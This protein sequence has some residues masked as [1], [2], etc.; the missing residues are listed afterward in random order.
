MA[1]MF[2]T[3]AIRFNYFFDIFSM[4]KT[5][6]NI[7]IIIVKGSILTIAYTKQNVNKEILESPINT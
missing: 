1:P 3:G 5:Q 4:K 2:E 7:I 6:I